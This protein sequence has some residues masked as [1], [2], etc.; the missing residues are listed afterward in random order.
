MR[1][2]K[3]RR[4]KNVYEFFEYKERGVWKLDKIMGKY[5]YYPWND[6]LQ[7][8]K[9]TIKNRLI[10]TSTSFLTLLHAAGKRM[11]IDTFEY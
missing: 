4:K 11:N 9:V 7:E 2:S 8:T 1:V 6:A 3:D 10:T 5:R